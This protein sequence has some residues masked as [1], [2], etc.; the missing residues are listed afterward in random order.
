MSNTPR[1]P[2]LASHRYNQH[3]IG[4]YH[5]DTRV[6]RWPDL[7]FC[8]ARSILSK[9][10]EA[11]FKNTVNGIVGG[12]FLHRHDRNEIIHD[13]NLNDMEHPLRAVIL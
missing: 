12:R 4:R 3:G 7:P 1:V 5:K 10:Q 11:T 13:S 2:I 6:F 9:F 8:C